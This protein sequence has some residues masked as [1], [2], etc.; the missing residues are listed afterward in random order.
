MA[1]FQH[2]DPARRAS[3][4]VLAAAQE[5]NARIP[6]DHRPHDASKGANPARRP[7]GAV[8]HSA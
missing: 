1:P 8:H 5:K 3:R 7:A 2:P 4:Q 6:T